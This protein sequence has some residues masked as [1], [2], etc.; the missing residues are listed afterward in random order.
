MWSCTSSCDELTCSH[1]MQKPYICACDYAT[2][3]LLWLVA[4]S[5]ALASDN[6]PS[7][8]FI[9]VCSRQ[10]VFINQTLKSRLFL[11][12]VYVNALESL[13]STAPNLAYLLFAAYL[14]VWVV[15]VLI[16]VYFYC[17]RCFRLSIKRLGV[18]TASDVTICIHCVWE[19]R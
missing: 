16:V 1:C 3:R 4:T 6:G 8:N 5:C 15:S 7:P 13:W 19:R 9:I 12:A 2:L 11:T 10:T 17:T 14:V 18:K